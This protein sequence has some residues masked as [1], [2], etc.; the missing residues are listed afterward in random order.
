[1]SRNHIGPWS[2]K[3]FGH[4]P[5]VVDGVQRS[6]VESFSW[7]TQSFLNHLRNERNIGF[8]YKEGRLMRTAKL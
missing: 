4:C 8:E 5:V 1:L 7:C 3:I 6:F 2:L